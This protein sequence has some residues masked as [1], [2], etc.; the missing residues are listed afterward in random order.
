MDK[1]L[2]V[3]ASY[4]GCMGGG[5]R[6]GNLWKYSGNGRTCTSSRYQA[7]FSHVA[8]VRG[9]DC[10]NPTVVQEPEVSPVPQSSIISHT[11]T[12]THTHTPM[13][14]TMMA[15]APAWPLS[16]EGVL[17]LRPRSGTSTA[18]SSTSTCTVCLCV[19]ACMCTCV[20]VHIYMHKDV[21][22]SEGGTRIVSSHNYY[23]T[24][25]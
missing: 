24:I 8:W 17:D 9:C 10:V 2:I 6:P 11:H 3:L 25:T 7:V 19:C 13:S 23:M 18:F 15:S 12:H 1:L 22:T 14:F 20:R 4:P 16:G 21:V 5:R